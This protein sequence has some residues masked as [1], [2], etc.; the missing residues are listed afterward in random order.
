MEKSWCSTFTEWSLFFFMPKGAPRISESHHHCQF[1]VPLLAESTRKKGFTSG[2]SGVVYPRSGGGS[3][4]RQPPV[5][6]PCRRAQHECRKSPLQSRT[7]GANA[8]A[9]PVTACRL[10]VAGYRPMIVYFWEYR[11]L[12]DSQNKHKDRRTQGNLGL[13]HLRHRDCRF[14][15]YGVGF[16]MVRETHH[17]PNCGESHSRTKSNWLLPTRRGDHGPQKKILFN[18]LF[19]V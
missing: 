8:L 19:R 18:F 17:L 3:S 5:V 15:M 9:V 16:R 7:Y 1:L 10:A 6:P 4:R 2:G 13:L 14:L 12:W 11:S